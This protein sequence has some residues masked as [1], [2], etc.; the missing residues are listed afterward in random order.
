[1]TENHTPDTGSRN[2]TSPHACTQNLAFLHA[3]PNTINRQQWW[4]QWSTTTMYSNTISCCPT[5]FSHVFLS[6]YHCFFPS[7]HVFCWQHMKRLTQIVWDTSH[8]GTHSLK[9]RAKLHINRGILHRFSL[10][11]HGIP[12][13]LQNVL[14]MF[15][16]LAGES[17]DSWC[18]NNYFTW[19]RL[20]RHERQPLSQ[21]C[22][23]LERQVLC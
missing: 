14:P 2:R 12:C 17:I 21:N 22:K 11:K 4:W 20:S 5:I 8:N 9:F 1:M 7:F 13:I 3:Q 16:W 6:S 18:R 10:K 19:H 15:L 23:Q